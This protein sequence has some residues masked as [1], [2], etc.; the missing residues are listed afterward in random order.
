MRV[1]TLASRV[2]TSSNMAMPGLATVRMYARTCSKTG[3][4]P[5]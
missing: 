1:L 5:P 3:Q 2:S 4:E